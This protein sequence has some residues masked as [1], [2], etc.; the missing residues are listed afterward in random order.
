VEFVEGDREAWA[1]YHAAAVAEA[2]RAGDRNNLRWL[3]TA[4]ISE[5][6][7]VGR[8]DEA[9][10]RC[11]VFLGEG[12][13]YADLPVMQLKALVHACRG[14]LDAGRQ[15]NARGLA[16]MRE[17]DDAQGGIPGRLAAAWTARVLGDDA[18]ASSLVAEALP[19]LETSRNRPQIVGAFMV[20]AIA[21]AG[22]L[23]RWRPSWEHAGGTRRL[24][25]ARLAA[26]GDVVAAADA[27]ASVSPFD[28]AVARLYAAEVLGDRAQLQRGLAFFR[29]VGASKIVRDA[30]A[31]L[32]A[33][34]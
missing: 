2:R 3:E 15:W 17:L 26:I 14:E 12:P 24:R 11:D 34:A 10:R 13:L 29:A 21:H 30:E 4:T 27:W 5:L 9:V 28:E 7:D 19:L 33:S 23:D 20:S 8:W 18:L 31:L 32:P 1:P 25:A 22:A 6:V 16:R